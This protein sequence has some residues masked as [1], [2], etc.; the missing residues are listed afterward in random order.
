MADFFSVWQDLMFCSTN[1]LSWNLSPTSAKKTC[2][3]STH[4]TIRY[5]YS[6]T[7]HRDVSRKE[8]QS[9]IGVGSFKKKKTFT[10]KINPGKNTYIR[11]LNS[12]F[13]SNTKNNIEK[14]VELLLIYILYRYFQ[15]I[16]SRFQI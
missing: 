9:E 6:V 10:K 1:W 3:D 13:T 2:S 8:V 5:R 15:K 11:C 16:L 12:L 14:K 4:N 7:V